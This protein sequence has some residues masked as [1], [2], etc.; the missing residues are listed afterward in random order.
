[1]KLSRSKYQNERGIESK[2]IAETLKELCIF[3][4]RFKYIWATRER[5]IVQLTEWENKN[6]C[7]VLIGSMFMLGKKTLSYS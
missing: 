3:G 7:T 2:V 5:I 1:M 4:Q 6:L